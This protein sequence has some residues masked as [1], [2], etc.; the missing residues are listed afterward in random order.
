MDMVSQAP[1]RAEGG[2]MIRAPM[3]PQDI[4]H[5]VA[6]RAGSLL[7]AASSCFCRCLQAIRAPAHGLYIESPASRLLPPLSPSQ[8]VI[9]D[10]PAG[11]AAI[12]RLYAADFNLRNKLSAHLC[13]LSDG[14][15]WRTLP[16]CKR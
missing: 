8:Q 9:A 6:G 7:P 1:V 14:Q 16:A 11:I 4:C 5:A 15:R 10:C 12:D 3:T 2:V 13:G